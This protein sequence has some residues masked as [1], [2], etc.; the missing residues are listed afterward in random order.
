MMDTDRK[1]TDLERSLAGLKRAGVVTQQMDGDLF[2]VRNRFHRLFHSVEVEKVRSQTAG[3][4]ADLSKI[5]EKVDEIRAEQQRRKVW[6][7]AVIGL[8]LC[9]GVVA[10]LI[11]RSYKKEI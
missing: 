5:G 1:I 3:F 6:G 10:L 7:A 8:L 11:Y 2:A 9:G 4:Q